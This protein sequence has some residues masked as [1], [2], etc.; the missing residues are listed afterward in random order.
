MV[1][2]IS[3]RTW[4]LAPRA[5]NHGGYPKVKLLIK[6]TTHL[7]TFLLFGSIIETLL[8]AGKFI[9]LFK[10]F[11]LLPLGVFQLG[12]PRY[13]LSLPSPSAMAMDTASITGHQ[14]DVVTTHLKTVSL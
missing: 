8:G 13:S 2:T 11:V 12:W 6:N 10:I 5:S 9:Y 3:G 4:L 14:V 7:V 1:C